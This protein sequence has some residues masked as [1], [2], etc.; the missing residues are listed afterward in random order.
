MA[1]AQTQE[2]RRLGEALPAPAPRTRLVW[3]A[4]V[5]I[6]PRQ[7]LGAGP[8]GER[9]IVPIVGG[10][11]WGGP[12]FES[13]QG[14][15]CP[16][17]ADRQ[18]LRPDGVKELWALYELETDDGAIVTVDNRVVI[19]ESAQ[20]ARYAVSTIRLS[21]P[22]GPHGWLNRRVFVGTLQ[23]LRPQREAVLIR[24]FLVEG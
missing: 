7:A 23:P 3:T 20:P 1:D 14:R 13:F 21:A 9:G 12:G 18:R 4:A 8:D 2:L 22:Q 11:F 10:R 24:G 15:V 19:D 6:A 5:D 16:G 17:G